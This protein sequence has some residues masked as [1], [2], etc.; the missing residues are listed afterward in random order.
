M[1]ERKH[2]NL[3]KQMVMVEEENRDLQKKNFDMHGQLQKLHIELEDL[4]AK[5]RDF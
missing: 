5:Q 2:K 1:L 3:Q 4:R